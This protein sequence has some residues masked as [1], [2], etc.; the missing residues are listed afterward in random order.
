LITFS[1]FFFFF[2]H[3]LLL[4]FLRR[5][6]EPFSAWK[7]RDRDHRRTVASAV[8]VAG[9]RVASTWTSGGRPQKG[10]SDATENG[11]NV[12]PARVELVD[13]RSTPDG[14]REK[15][16]EI[17][18]DTNTKATALARC[19]YVYFGRDNLHNSTNWRSNT[20]FGK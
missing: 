10:R 1:R 16:E 11:T 2:L 9:W 7:P 3:Y 4:V 18:R 17:G 12:K 6:P 20:F 13:G 15:P 19:M 5:P 14:R 8:V